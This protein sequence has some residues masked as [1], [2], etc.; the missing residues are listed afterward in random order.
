MFDAIIEKRN[1][2]ALNYMFH[3][4][5]LFLSSLLSIT[6]PSIILNT[7]RNI[8]LSV[9]LSYIKRKS[10][11]IIYT[12]LKNNS[13]KVTYMSLPGYDWKCNFPHIWLMVG[14]SESKSVIFSYEGTSITP[15]AALLLQYHEDLLWFLMTY[16]ASHG[17]FWN[18]SME[19]NIFFRV[20]KS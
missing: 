15:I 3:W 19:R 17:P 7:N 4:W 13:G 6:A 1:R 2:M 10:S 9:S 18:Y 5:I 14:Q 11:A 8:W 12:V 16:Y 20:S